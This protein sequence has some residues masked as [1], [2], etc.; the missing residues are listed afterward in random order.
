MTVDDTDRRILEVLRTDARTS[1]R[2]LA[3]QLHLSRA[4]A[5]ARVRRLQDSGVIRGFT[6]VVDPSLLGLGLPA[7]VHVRIKQNSWKRFKAHVLG[8]P[9]AVHVALVAGDFD[10]TMLVRTRDAEHLRSLVLEQIQS[11]P[12]VLGTQT[13][14]IFEE[15][16]TPA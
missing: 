13:V 1:V 8:L 3:A 7:Y 6:T 5:Y 15:A 11:M 10:V 2:D 4:N 12:E 16:L 14:L 9:E